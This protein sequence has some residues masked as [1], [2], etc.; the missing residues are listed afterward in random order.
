MNKYKV[1][2]GKVTREY[3]APNP[4]AARL[5]FSREEELA[6]VPEVTLV[7]EGVEPV[8]RRYKVTWGIES[9]EV[10]AVHKDDAWSQFV[11]GRED[12]EMYKHPNAHQRIIEDLGPVEE[13][14]AKKKKKAKA[15]LLDPDAPVVLS[16]VI[17]QTVELAKDN[18]SRMRSVEH[19]QQIVA[20]DP[21]KTV[22]EAAEKRLTEL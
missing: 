6:D 12:T 3:E 16:P 10:V 19:L 5:Q 21:R 18:I 1:T 15:N 4:T 17:D 14:G 8:K 11:G 22:V 20:S 7:E 9:R 2:L 13:E